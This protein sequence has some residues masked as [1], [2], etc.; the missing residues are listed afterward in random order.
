MRVYLDGRDVTAGR[1]PQVKGLSPEDRAGLDPHHP[2]R[3]VPP[4]LLATGLLRLAYALR[5][6]PP[7]APR[8]P[9]VDRALRAA[10]AAAAAAGAGGGGGPE[11]GRAPVPSVPVR[12]S[13]PQ[14]HRH[15]ATPP[16]TP[17]PLPLRPPGSRYPDGPQSRYGRAN[18]EPGRPASSGWRRP[19]RDGPRRAD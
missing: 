4:P 10:A 16:A 7:A 11:G 1:R 17:P 5:A 3:P 15:T 2:D 9:G 6:L 19:M 8:P 18:K 12:L 14:H 13:R